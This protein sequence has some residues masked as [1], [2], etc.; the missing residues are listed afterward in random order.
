[1]SIADLELQVKRL[2]TE[3]ERVM[4]KLE[5]LTARDDAE[6]KKLSILRDQARRLEVLEAAARDRMAAKKDQKQFR[7]RQMGL[8]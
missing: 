1:M 5:R 3:N 6:P 2:V 7:A 8:S 4:Q